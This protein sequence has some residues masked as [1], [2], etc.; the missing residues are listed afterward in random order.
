MT[1][2]P[3]T[4]KAAAMLSDNDTL[5]L[6]QSGVVHAVTLAT[7]KTYFGS[8]AA[9]AVGSTG[10]TGATGGTAGSTGTT[11]ATAS[12]A[13]VESADGTSVT[14]VGPTIV[15]AA[16]NVYS[17][18][19]DG[20]VVTNGAK[21]DGTGGKPSTANVVQEYYKAHQFYQ[22][23]SAGNWFTR[24]SV[25]AAYT[26][27]VTDP[28]AASASTGSTGATGATGTTTTTPAAQVMRGVN[29]AGMEF[30]PAALPGVGGQQY[31]IGQEAQVPYWVAKGMKGFRIPFLWER[32][33]N[34]P[35]GALDP[36]FMG[37]LDNVVNA[38]H[39]AGGY[40][41]I[42]MHNY[43]RLYVGGTQYIIG[44]TSQATAAMFGD[45]WAKLATRYKAL[46]RVVFNLMNE[47]H[48]VTL[49]TLP[50]T[51]NTAIAAIRATGA[52]QLILVAGSFYTTGVTWISSGNAAAMVNITDSGKN[53][54][55]DIHQYLDSDSSGSSDV[56]VV[57]SG[58]SR[59]A[60][61][62]NWARSH[63]FRG[64]LGEFNFG[65]NSQCNT[66][67]SALLG[68]MASNSDVW[69][70]WSY[71]AAGLGW[72]ATDSRTIQPNQL[73]PP[74]AATNAYDKPQVAELLQF[75]P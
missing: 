20:Y 57:G 14:T 69:M 13:L 62:T 23:N 68:Y 58:A 39:N 9:A 10:A 56:C 52:T 30:T 26:G 64:F 65:N 11:G 72:S 51:F 19:A 40:P 6:T 63:G 3:P 4:T 42:D 71:F 44:E 59:L 27:P 18:S 17:I 48:D 16:K 32:A 35:M 61:F 5:P 49:S 66:E 12:P 53:F 2:L 43:M 41:I 29:L 22:K 7:L 54:A 37:Y 15:D 1:Y 24:T 46:P 67:A 25:T 55:F 45:V 36:T 33:Q 21:E 31:A 34:T 60:D 47:P 28:T 8:G 50:G 38:V 73:S 70:G 74:Y 75:L